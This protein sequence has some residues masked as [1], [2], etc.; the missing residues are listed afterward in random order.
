[1]ETNLEKTRSMVSDAIHR[2]LDRCDGAATQDGVGFNG[3]DRKFVDDVTA[4]GDK[5]WT[6]KQVAALHKMLKKYRGQ[7]SDLGVDYALILPV[8]L[9]EAAIRVPG[10]PMPA[11]VLQQRKVR[12]DRVGDKIALTFPYLPQLVAK[13]R[14]ISGREWDGTRKSWLVP[15]SSVGLADLVKFIEFA[16]EIL[17]V[18]EQDGISAELETLRKESEA[19]Q[20]AS[21]SADNDFHVEGLGGELRPF[22]RAGVAYAVKAKR[23]FIADEM[24]LGK[25]VQALATIHHLK[26]YPALVVCPASLKIN[27]LREAGKWLPGKHAQVLPSWFKA[28]VDVTN[29]EMLTKLKPQLLARGYKAIIFDEC[30]YLKNNKAI[31]TKA[32]VEVADGIEIR[33]GLSGTPLVNRPAELLAQLNVLGRLQDLGGF[34]RFASRYLQ[35]NFKGFGTNLD[36]L[37]REMRSKC[38]IRRKKADVLKELP[39]KVRT[40]VEMPLADR[41]AYDAAAEGAEEAI[42][43]IQ[44]FRHEAA[45]QKL[46]AVKEW[47]QEFL[48]T[49]EKLV[50]F[51]AHVDI[52]DELVKAFP[53]CVKIQGEDQVGNRQKAVDRFQT[54]PDCKLIVCSLK[55]AGVGL[56]LTA[57]SN[58]AFV[59]QGWTPGDMDQAEDR[60]HRIGQ[61]DSVTAWYLVATNTIDSDMAALIEKK[62]VSIAQATDADK[63]KIDP[64]VMGDLIKKYKPMVKTETT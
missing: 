38:F 21:M 13:V 54:D 56:T 64:S 20:S 50:L 43:A 8:E 26:A 46:P 47:V 7:L 17:P 24:G 62:R 44:L 12:I 61:T 40:F 9:L 30:H 23:T 16:K 53:D 57:A 18:E 3:W 4:R 49:G 58:V 42:A 35:W 14:E 39:A 33:L 11:S 41:K 1:M 34:K 31:R 59:E 52:Q 27:W 6:P 28:D 36:E 19:M 51:A 55:A 10:S 15:I 2:M 37:Q 63:S 25:T 48:D 60:C 45:R 29:Y 5:T 32:A 22:Q